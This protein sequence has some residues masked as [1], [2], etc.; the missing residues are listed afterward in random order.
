[1]AAGMPLPLFNIKSMVDK[2]FTEKIQTWLTKENKTDVDIMNGALMLLQINRNRVL[3][4]NICA[5]PQKYLGKVEYE[6]NKHLRY[7]LD[8]LT[9][10]DVHELEQDIITKVDKVLVD[11]SPS[12]DNNDTNSHNGKRADHESLPPEIQRLWDVNAERYKK[13]KEIRATCDTLELS[14]DRYEYLKILVDT[15]KQYKRDFQTYD[16]YDPNSINEDSAALVAKDIN[17]ARAYISKNK[18]ALDDL[19]TANDEEMAS[20]LAEKIQER[21]DVL[22][23]AKAEMSDDLKKWLAERGFNI[24]E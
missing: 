8:G 21:V 4:Q 3:Y 24:D 10:Q 1:V 5:K 23:K 17:N 15:Y 6:L 9:L 11:D 18:Q 12:N 2:S 7:R 14:C 13:M 22:V 16:D 19:I 20:T